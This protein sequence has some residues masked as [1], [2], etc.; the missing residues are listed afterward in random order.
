MPRFQVYRGLKGHPVGEPGQTEFAAPRFACQRPIVVT[1]EHGNPKAPEGDFAD[2][3]EPVT[4]LYLQTASL[5][6]ACR[7]GHLERVGDP[8][9]AKDWA[10]AHLR[11]ATLMPKD[12][13]EP[14]AT[15]APATAARA[16]G[17]E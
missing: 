4:K 15:K 5:E 9:V 11:A 16:A 1:D 7:Q 3:F 14:V 17:G 13:P 8:I 6:K 12:Q 2:R 10:E